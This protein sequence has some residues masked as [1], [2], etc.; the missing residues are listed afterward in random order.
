MELLNLIIQN[1]TI[2]IKAEEKK[3][4]KGEEKE[5]DLI[6][7]FGYDSL[8]LVSLI[9]CIENTFGITI[10]D[11]YISTSFFRKYTNIK[12]IV[13]ESEKKNAAE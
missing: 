5:W 3:K 10:E 9:V 1:A 7:D 8:A 4:K 12:K 2:E 6:E 13:E 11:D